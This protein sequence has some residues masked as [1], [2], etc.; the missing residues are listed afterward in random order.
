MTGH[1]GVTVTYRIDHIQIALSNIHKVYVLHTRLEDNL[2]F[3]RYISFLFSVEMLLLAFY[4]YFA[5][6]KRKLS[7]LKSI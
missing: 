2:C 1:V 7:K 3:T 5:F 4:H 6:Y